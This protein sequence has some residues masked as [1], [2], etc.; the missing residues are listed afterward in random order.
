MKT[1][2]NKT[3]KSNRY[4]IDHTLIIEK[5]CLPIFKV[6]RVLVQHVIFQ[7]CAKTIENI[8]NIIHS[9]DFIEQHRSSLYFIPILRHLPDMDLTC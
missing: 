3:T 9:R 5:L 8:K 6:A 7:P 2:Y 1:M 4:I